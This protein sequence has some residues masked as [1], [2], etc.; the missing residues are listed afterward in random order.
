MVLGGSGDMAAAEQAFREATTRD[1]DNAQYAYNLGLAL[2]KQNKRNEAAVAFR[3]ALELDPRF[4]AARQ[5]LA[6]LQ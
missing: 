5:R 4:G 6:E 2:A 1:A 3:R